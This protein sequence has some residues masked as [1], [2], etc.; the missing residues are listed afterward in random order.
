MEPSPRPGLEQLVVPMDD[1]DDLN[2][3]MSGEPFN[4]QVTAEQPEAEMTLV[5]V[6]SL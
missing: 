4:P 3:I 5:T 1:G 2:Q 6:A